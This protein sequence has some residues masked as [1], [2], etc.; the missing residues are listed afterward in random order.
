MESLDNPSLQHLNMHELISP[1]AKRPWRAGP[2]GTALCLLA[3]G[4]IS[5]GLGGWGLCL[6]GNIGF[7]GLGDA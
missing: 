2:A 1:F 7:Q 5:E 6:E 4:G 3:V